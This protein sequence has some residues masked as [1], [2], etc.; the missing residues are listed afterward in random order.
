MSFIL[1]VFFYLNSQRESVKKLLF[2]SLSIFAALAVLW[3]PDTGIV[4]FI[5]WIIVLLYRELLDWRTKGFWKSL[6]SGLKTIAGALLCLGG[7]LVVFALYTFFLSGSWPNLPEFTKY[8]NLFYQDGYYMMPMPLVHPWNIVILIYMLGLFFSIRYFCQRSAWVV[9]TDQP[10]QAGEGGFYALILALSVLGAG[11]FSYYQGR[12]HDY[13]LINPSWP[14]LILLILFADVILNRIVAEFK[15]ENTW[16]DKLQKYAHDFL[17]NGL[18]GV[19]F[20][21]LAMSIPSILRDL[22]EYTRLISSRIEPIHSGLPDAFKQDIDFIEAN[23]DQNSELLI[24]SYDAPV[25][26]LYVRNLK[27]LPIPGFGEELIWRKDLDAIL[28]Y[29][30]NPTPDMRIFWQKGYDFIDPHEY[31]NLTLA[32]MS[33]QGSVELFVKK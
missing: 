33:D 24:L 1:L 29:L 18:F 10:A 3:N 23:S 19:V 6:A 15:E 17:V 2:F 22:P 13:N 9:N 25:R 7:V 26:Y 30:K 32:K 11:L 21:F 27:T 12:S 8:M 5:T 14:A 4:V 28:A 31:P 16:K 20:F